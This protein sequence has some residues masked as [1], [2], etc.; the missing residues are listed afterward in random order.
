[1][2]TLVH[3]QTALAALSM[4]TEG[5][6]KGKRLKLEMGLDEEGQRAKMICLSWTMTL[7]LNSSPSYTIPPDF[8][9]VND[10]VV[11][12]QITRAVSEGKTESVSVQHLAG[13][14]PR[15]F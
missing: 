8:E 12:F 14:I 7:T 6:G 2:M 15:K 4:M 11:K 10:N 3:S 9:N 13:L 1:M 5:M